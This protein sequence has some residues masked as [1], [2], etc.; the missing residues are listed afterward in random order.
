M[1]YPFLY[2]PANTNIYGMN[3]ESEKFRKLMLKK[4]KRE[5]R[6]PKNVL[7]E[8]KSEDISG[9]KFEDLDSV[10]QSLGEAEEEKK[11]KAK[12]KKKAESKKGHRSVEKEVN[13]GKE[14]PEE[15]IEAN[16]TEEDL[17]EGP[18]ESEIEGITSNICSL[19]LNEVE[20]ESEVMLDQDDI[21]LE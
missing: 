13:H 6:M 10:L 5:S 16:E 4:Q 20:V 21:D 7:S 11:G 12:K 1:G 17:L 19:G 14:D 15:R 18:E 3:P 2:A 9:H 8:F